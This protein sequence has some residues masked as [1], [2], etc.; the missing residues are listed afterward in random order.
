MKPTIPIK[1]KPTTDKT[2]I[3]VKVLL[4]LTGV[5]GSSGIWGVGSSSFGFSL[6]SI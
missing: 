5:S 4:S 2:K 3:Y 6:Y 1:N